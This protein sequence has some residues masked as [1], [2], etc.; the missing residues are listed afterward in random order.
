[1][2]VLAVVQNGGGLLVALG[3]DG[4]GQPV[5]VQTQLKLIIISVAV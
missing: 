2:A 5:L 4:E 1:V 3:V